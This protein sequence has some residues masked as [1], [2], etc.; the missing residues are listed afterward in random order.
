MMLS[1]DQREQIERDVL[2]LV[3]SQL[4][5][6]LRGVTRDDPRKL[7]AT[8]LVYE[9]VSEKIATIEACLPELATSQA[10]VLEIGTGF[11]A[12]T[13]YTRSFHSWDIYGC[14]PDFATIDAS[15]KLAEAVGLAELPVA[16]AIGEQLPF[17]EASFDLVYSSN[18]L[19]HVYSPETVIR[20]AVR[21]LRPE[22][23]LFFT[24]PNYGSWWEGHY[25]IPWIPHM[26]AWLAKI[27]VRLWGREPS[28]ID[29]LQLITVSKIK[30]ML[31]PLRGQIELITLGE[32]VWKHRMETLEFG[33]WGS[34]HRLKR[35]VR[36]FGHLRL[37]KLIIAVGNMLNWQT[38]IV[39][40]L[41]KAGT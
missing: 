19:E 12:F 20:E 41:R 16:S 5:S 29:G 38:P 9:H 25:G 11:G 40:V 17:P 13:V 28:Y 34:T 21:V 7:A 27:Y 39:L 26:P 32:E 6:W 2:P 18:V 22:G 36:V 31:K 30:R 35:L 33:E 3:A 4:A 1:P 10:R 23:Y 37:T 14:E 15:G 24:I 8:H